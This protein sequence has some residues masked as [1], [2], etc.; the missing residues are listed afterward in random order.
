MKAIEPPPPP[1][2]AAPPPPTN[3]NAKIQPPPAS[4]PKYKYG[5]FT[6]SKLATKLLYYAVEGFGK[7]TFAATAPDPMIVMTPG[8]SGYVTLRKAGRVPDVATVLGEDDEPT[9]VDSWED[10]L[11]IANEFPDTEFKTFALDTI[12]GADKLCQSRVLQRDFDGSLKAFNHY[13]KGPMACTVEWKRLMSAVE[14]I[15]ASGKNVILL[16][17][18]TVKKHSNP[19]DVDCDRYQCSIGKEMGEMAY[20]ICD[21][22]LFG[23]F[24]SVIEPTEFDKGRA[25]KGKGI[26]G[27]DRVVYTERRDAYDAKNR[28]GMPPAI[29]IPAD[30][31]KVFETIWQYIEQGD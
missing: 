9:T 24:V 10:L 7:T 25:T 8:E 16:G 6:K 17:H 21:V 20:Q 13:N 29:S 22:V 31:T 15:A 27:A 4:K 26:G 3:G 28:Y 19:S 1:A 23:N 5:K 30:P 18:V 14:K 11:S 12:G 2:A